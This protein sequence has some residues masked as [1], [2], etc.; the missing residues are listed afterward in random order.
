MRLPRVIHKFLIGSRGRVAAGIVSRVWNAILSLAIYPIYLHFVG[1][2]SLGV[3]AAYASI[4]AVITLFDGSLAPSL[5]KQLVKARVD[6]SEWEKSFNLIKTME[7]IYWGLAVFA[8][9]LFFLVVPFISS[10][11]LNPSH[12]NH[13]E[14]KNALYIA[15]IGLTL[16]WPSTLYVSGLVGM[17]KQ[18]LLALVG[19][20][21]STVKVVI[22]ILFLWATT[23][24]VT[25]IFLV[26]TAFNLIQTI[27]MRHYFFSAIPAKFNNSRFSPQLMKEIWRFSGGLSL[28]TIT[29]VVLFQADKL[30]FSKL[31]KLENFGF[32]SIS[33]S[34]ANSLFIVSGAMF[35]V[36]FPKFSELIL[37]KDKDSLSEYYHLSCQALAF[38]IFPISAV[39]MF[40]SYDLLL[41]WT[42]NAQ[43]ASEGAMILALFIIGN[44]LNCALSVPYTLQLSY[45]LTKTALYSNILALLI[46]FPLIN[47]L[48]K[49]Y[50][51]LSGPVSW[52]LVNFMLLT[53]I[54]SV[55]HQKILKGEG[56][57]WFFL[58]FAL[59]LFI[60]IMIVYCLKCR[61]T[62][63]FCLYDIDLVNISSMY[64]SSFTR[65]P[66]KNHRDCHFL[67]IF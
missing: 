48:F 3:I 11:W 65:F 17:E 32:Y 10:S 30:A 52:S 47:I 41:L 22:T 45:G 1:A 19:T 42:N 55:S 37:A 14:L 33:T 43:L 20:I 21:S 59:P 4:Q 67:D 24:S 15:A 57:K 40:Y 8:G 64:I 56:R 39:T 29:S 53:I 12:I 31:L 27:L 38:F 34:I 7:I 54:A 58:D 46:Y 6:N 16:Q 9:F 2:E 61:K 28:I 13:S 51:V 23:P 44:L 36:I 49:K 25:V 5:T 66:E 18:S 63:Q 26:G 62:I 60:A 50:N 35:S